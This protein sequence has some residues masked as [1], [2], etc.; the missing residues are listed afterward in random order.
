MFWLLEE[1]GIPTIPD[2]RC[3]MR[4]GRSND[5]IT[6]SQFIP[7][8][9]RDLKRLDKKHVDDAPLAEVIDPII[10]K[11]TPDSLA[12]LKRC[13]RMH[14]LNGSWGGSG[15]CLVCNAGDWLLVW[16]VAGDTALKQRTGTTTRCFDKQ[17]HKRRRVCRTYM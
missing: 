16:R 14:T 11:N 3:L 1:R 7:S 8:F 6:R 15:E 12:E 5:S 9:R 13:H 2:A 17:P 10:E 4:P